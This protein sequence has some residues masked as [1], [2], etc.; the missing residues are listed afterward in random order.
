[1]L[2]ASKKSATYYF[3]ENNLLGEKKGLQSYMC[4]HGKP[5]ASP[6]QNKEKVP[7]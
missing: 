7:L 2:T 3:S 1:M 6:R 5:C 4:N